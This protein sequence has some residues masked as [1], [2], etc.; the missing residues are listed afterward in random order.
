[1]IYADELD[2]HQI[3]KLLSMSTSSLIY[4]FNLTEFDDSPFQEIYPGR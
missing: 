2:G 4:T 3:V 1:M